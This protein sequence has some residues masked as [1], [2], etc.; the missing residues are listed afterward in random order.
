MTRVMLSALVALMCLSLVDCGGD[1]AQRGAE[2]LEG[3]AEDLWGN[4]IDLSD[5][6][7]GLAILHPFSPAD[8]GYCL[9]DDEFI[10]TNY[11]LNTLGRGGAFLGMSPFATQLDV[12]TYQKHYRESFPVLMSPPSLY[13]YHRNGYP[14]LCVFR[15]GK[16]VFSNSP[17]PYEETFKRLRMDFWGEEIPITPTSNL[18]LATRF[19]CENKTGL[20]VSVIPDG[21]A[22]PERSGAESWTTKHESDLT[23]DDLEMNLEIVGSLDALDLEYMNWADT[24]VEITSEKITVGDYEFPADKVGLAACFPNPRDPERYVVL[25]LRGSGLKSGRYDNWADYTVYRD[26]PDGQAE[27]LMTGLFERDGARWFYSRKKAWV[28]AETVS[29]CK[30]GKCPAPFDAEP[31]DEKPPYSA[32]ASGRGLSDYGEV[33]TLGGADCRFPSLSAGAGGGCSVAWEEERDIVLAVLDGDG[34][35][36]V[37]PIEEGRWDSFNPVVVAGTADTW[38][39]YLSDQDGFYRLYGSY[40]KPGGGMNE[41]QISG[42]GAIDCVTPAAVSDGKGKMVVAW[43][44]WRA[45]QRFMKYREINGRMLGETNDAQIKKSDID[46]TN[47][48]YA[49]L[50]LDDAGGVWGVWNQHYPITLGVCSGD[51]IEEA[52]LVSGEMGAYPS[53]VIDSAGEHWVFWESYMKDVV[54]G[55]PHRILAS[56]GGKD[57]AKWTL[58]DDLSAAAGTIYNQTP[59]AA[60]DGDGILWV[61]WSGRIDDAGPWGVYLR[62]STDDG[63]SEPVRVSGERESA[64]APA[65]AAGPD[66]LWLGWHSGTGD[67]MR[68]K[69]LRYGAGGTK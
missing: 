9:F 36:R 31:V 53:L 13:F 5:Y 14:W 59:E 25:R 46:Y 55:K 16:S 24:P 52:V 44:E 15:D 33:W 34:D 3:N 48:W 66:G 20:A 64:R 58:P 41:A 39:F 22:M 51:M 38:V 61:A 23:E 68:V 63:W 21:R 28:S 29:F 40:G 45:N 10:Y 11:G 12:Y 43:S 8:C 2:T 18:Q 7:R 62:H 6:T 47:A 56:R 17:H 69:V 54:R 37:F 67:D 1:A 4:V 65:I 19:I 49:S 57:G 32:P 30:G 27:V 42:E 35:A 50:A 26:G 60:V